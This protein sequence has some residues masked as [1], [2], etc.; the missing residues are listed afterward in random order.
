MSDH[1][2]VTNVGNENVHPSEA[3][4]STKGKGKA[5]DPTPQDMSMDEDEESSEEEEGA[6]E[7][8]HDDPEEEDADNMEE[9][10]TE[11]IINDGRRTRGKTI[12]FAQA[13]KDAGED[14]DDDEDDDDD[15][16]DEDAM[17]E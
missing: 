13:A 4:V 14:L 11:N 2:G 6:E 10:S 17:K 1:N 16:E 8:G 3:P 7:E 12:D 15:F 5:I 9:I